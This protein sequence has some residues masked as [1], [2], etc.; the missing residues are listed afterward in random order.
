MAGDRTVKLARFLV[1]RLPASEPKNPF[2][3]IL[4]KNIELSH[5]FRPVACPTASGPPSRDR[6]KLHR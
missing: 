6:R 4:L 1:V 2:S 5:P 3:A